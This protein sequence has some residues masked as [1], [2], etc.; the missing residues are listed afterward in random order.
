MRSE[1]GVTLTGLVT[2]IVIFVIILGTMATI[3]ASFYEN[4][5]LVTE[6]PK[7]ISEFNKFCMFFVVDIKN[8]TEISSI[9]SFSLVLGDGTTYQYSD[10]IIYRN[11]EQVAKYIQEFCF[12]STTY[13]D[14][15]NEFEK[16]IV[17]VTAKIGQSDEIVTRD[18]DFVLKYW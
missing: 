8:N 9:T 18:I 13:T 14:T 6:S 5:G 15:E 2:Y 16:Q 17:N 12:T 4:I 1:K 7:Y 3:S 11:G 10:G